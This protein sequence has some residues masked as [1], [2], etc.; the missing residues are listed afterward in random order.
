MGAQTMLKP[1]FTIANQIAYNN[2]MVLPSNITKVGK[3][4]WYDVKGNAIQKQ[5]V[6]E[7]GEKVVGL[8]ADDWIEAIKEGKNEPSSFVISPFSAVQQQIKRMLK[9]QL[10]TRIDIERTKI[11]QWVDK[12]IGTV[13]TFQGKEAQKVYFVIGT[14]NTQDGA[15]NWSCEKPNL[16]NVAVTRAKKEF[17][18]IGDMQRIQSKPFYETIFKER[19]V[20]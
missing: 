12:S 18:V 5:F 19:D 16:L 9:Q 2:K 3:T 1:M 13:H 14:D 17:Y 8:L 6:K 4:G 11:N 15:V 7:H 20:K 10:P